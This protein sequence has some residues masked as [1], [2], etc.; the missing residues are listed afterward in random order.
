MG[1]LTVNKRIEL[2]K[3]FETAL[4]HNP[5]TLNELAKQLG[6]CR[7]TVQGLLRGDQTCHPKSYY[8]LEN[9][10]TRQE[11]NVGM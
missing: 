5:V 9:W 4:M 7:Q 2:L 10:L 3:R 6:M 1:S 11:K 8:K